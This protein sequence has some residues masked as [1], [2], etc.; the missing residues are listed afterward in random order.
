M[1]QELEKIILRTPVTDLKRGK[2]ISDLKRPNADKHVLDLQKFVRQVVQE[3]K[4]PSLKLWQ[5]MEGY[6]ELLAGDRQAAYKRWQG[7]EKKLSK[8]N[9][10]ALLHQLAIWH[11]LLDVLNLDEI[12]ET[13]R[14]SVAY[15]VRGE[16]TFKENPYFEPFLQDWLAQDYAATHPGK[17]VL[18]AWSFD[19]LSYNPDFKTLDDLLKLADSKDPV[20]LEKTLMIDTNPDFAKT[21]L[22]EMRGTYLLS[23]GQP[24]AALATL[25][26]IKPTQQINLAKFTPFRE[27]VGERVHRPS[28]D[29]SS[30]H[31]QLNRLQIAQKII[32]FQTKAKIAEAENDSTNAARHYYLLGL[33][34]YNMSYF[35]YEWEV[36]D[37]YRSGYN[38]LRLAQ[39]PV[40]PLKNSPNGNRENTDVGLALSYFEQALQWANDPEMAAR[41]AFMAARCRQKQWFCDPECNYRPGSKLIPTLPNHYMD[42]YILLM[43]KYSETKFYSAVVKQCKWLEAYAQ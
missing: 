35:G 37:F 21:R 26:K 31:Y 6:V 42:Y 28:V 33:G 34:Y 24:E 4:I 41:A 20:L 16:N 11:C 8:K 32:E 29:D 5:A 36:S 38:Q 43:T 30:A 27:K 3:K 39:G 23:L 10:K 7:L 14:D 15:A 1:V 17:A 19:A 22:L 13:K 40:F 25:Q 2:A 9:D 18:T 12:P